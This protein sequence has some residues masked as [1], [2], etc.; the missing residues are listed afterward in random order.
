MNIAEYAIKKRVITLVF[1]LFVVIG[2]LMSYDSLGRLED[3]EFTIKEALV[4]TNYP[5]ATAEEVALEVSDKLETKIQEMAEVKQIRSLNKRGLSVITVEMK[6]QYGKDDLPIIWQ[7]LRSKVNDISGQLPPG[8]SKPVINDDFGDVYGVLFAIT[9]DGYSYKELYDYAKLFRKE[10]LLVQDVAKIDIQGNQQETI[11]IELDPTVTANLGIGLDEIFDAL[12]NKN[13][14]LPA[15][16]INVGDEYITIHPTGQIDALTE[17]G[18]LV[19]QSSGQNDQTSLIYLK[20]IA[21]IYR[22]YEEPAQVKIRYQG[23]PAVTLGISTIQGGNVVTMGD[24]VMK[25]IAELQSQVPVGIE[26]NA[27]SLQSE[28]VTASINAFIINLLEAVAIVVAVLMIFMGLRSASIIG[29]ALFVTVMATFILMKSQG[30][31]LERISLGALIIALGML[32]DNAIVVI[33]G[34]LVRIQ[35]GVDRVKAASE[36]V[37]QNFWPLLGATLIAILAFGAIGLSQDKT[38]EYTRSLFYVILY[39][40]LLSWL[41]AVTLVPLLGVMFIKVDSSAAQKDPYASKFYQGLKKTVTFLIQ[42]RWITVMVMLGLLYSSF[43]AFSQLKDSFFP[44]STRDQ[45][46]MQLYFPE[47]TNIEKVESVAIDFEKA[48]MA[49]PETKDVSTFINS[50]APRFLLT[51]SPEKDPNGYVFMVVTVKDFKK[52]DEIMNRFDAYALENFP[53]AESRAEKFALGPTKPAVEAVI[54]GEDPDVLRQLGEQIKD[55][56]RENNAY[57]IR[58]EWRERVKQIVPV[59]DEAKASEVGVTLEDFNKSLDMNFSGLT[60]GYYRESDEMIP[61]V[62]RATEKNRLDIDQINNLQVWSSGARK[63]IPIYQVISKMD[64]RFVDAASHRKNRSRTY[65]VMCDAQLGALKSSIFAKVQAPIEAIKMPEGYRLE[66]EG[67]YESSQDAQAGL[68][69]S[70]PLFLGLMVLIVIMLFNAIKEPLI[71]W[72]TV[73]LALVG[74]GFGL[75]IADQPFDFMALLG[76]LSLTGMLIKNSIV[77]LDQ[78]NLELQEGLEKFDAIIVSV[79]S[80]TRPVAMGALT[81]VLGMIPLLSDAFF[82]AMA[83]TIMAGLAFAT[84]LTLLFVPVLFAIIH[85]VSVPK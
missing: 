43:L 42:R 50:G 61:M 11:Y 5:G 40:L 49:D 72:L 52:I 44:S 12:N 47:D 13:N 56:M 84:I 16:K 81:T 65:K 74:V 60:V 67:E 76:F 19:I 1:T 22:G 3:P 26:L 30:I 8:V 36:V 27:I 4:I 82:V 18:N 20:D 25:R 64:V 6:D 85:R 57:A 24:L 54:Y 68:M 51:Y 10:L 23:Q 71:I 66:W 73:P 31:L 38:G 62:T 14:V 34:M 69:S 37:Q 33:D 53:E 9:C 29:A 35:K 59:F 79:L 75:Y 41:V 7:K 83:V 70:I 39:S 28:R 80:R 45:F 63:Y 2:G 58:T 55:I 32:V 15:G 48:I 46:M 78:I 17:I 77:L 21:T